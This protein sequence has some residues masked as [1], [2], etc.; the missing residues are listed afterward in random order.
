[1]LFLTGQQPHPPLYT[2]T[3]TWTDSTT[4][5]VSYNIYE[6]AGPCP[7]TTTTKIGSAGVGAT[8]F[9]DPTQRSS[10]VALSSG[11]SNPAFE[12]CYLI[13][14]VSPAGIESTAAPWTEDLTQPAAV[15]GVV[16]T[17]K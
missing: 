5:N 9:T 10:G 16:G 13:T 12:Y 8:S 4:P 15:T 1:M 3:L 14:T 17:A 6:G 2:I 11:G 7:Q